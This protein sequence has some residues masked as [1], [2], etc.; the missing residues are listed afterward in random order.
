MHAITIFEKRGL[1]FE[2]NLRGV[3]ARVSKEKGPFENIISE[4]KLNNNNNNN[5]NKNKNQPTKKPQ[6]THSLILLV[7]EF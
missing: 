4:I 1:E 6:N 7:M 2:G 5:K 3:Y